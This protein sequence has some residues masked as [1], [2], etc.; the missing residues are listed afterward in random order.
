MKMK[1]A[2]L[3]SMIAASLPAAANELRRA[4][5]PIRGQYIVVLKDSAFEVSRDSRSSRAVDALSMAA[6]MAASHRLEVDRVYEHA[7]KGFVVKNANEKQI[8]KLLWDDRVAFVEEDGMVLAGLECG[9]HEYACG[10]R[11]RF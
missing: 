11:V 10:R 7:L 4:E 2:V 3:C 8:E 9:D 1:L 6:D 5:A